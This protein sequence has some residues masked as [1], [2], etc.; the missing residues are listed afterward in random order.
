M[1]NEK[2]LKN[3]NNIISILNYFNFKTFI[4]I[5]YKDN[6]IFII[7]IIARNN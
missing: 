3:K 6:E 7:I 2:T 5:I 1:L 4:L